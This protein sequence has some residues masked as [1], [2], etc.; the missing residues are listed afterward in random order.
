MSPKPSVSLSSAWNGRWLWV[1]GVLVALSALGGY[2]SQR[3]KT[4]V[5]RGPIEIAAEQLDFG[6]VPVQ[7]RFQWTV[8]LKNISDRTLRVTE[9]A[10][11]CDCT[12]IAPNAVS[13]APGETED[14]QLTLDL[15]PPISEGATRR[16]RPFSVNLTATIEGGRIPGRV[17]TISGQVRSPLKV[18]PS[19]VDFG[20]SL[21]EGAP[22]KPMSVVVESHEPCSELAASCNDRRVALTVAKV[23]GLPNR[24]RVS[25]FPSTKLPVGWHEFTIDLAPVLASGHNQVTVSIPVVARVVPEFGFAP[26]TGHLGGVERGQTL[27]ETATLFSRRKREFIVSKAV[28]HSPHVQVTRVPSHPA[29]FRIHCKNGQP[30]VHSAQVEFLIE[31]DSGIEERTRTFRYRVFQ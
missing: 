1:V 17:W 19:K 2:F 18:S 11:S 27:I 12:S 4:W 13:L 3:R 8:S 24:F 15:Q 31:T 25:V 10:A 26:A 16:I 20:E 5:D 23:D 28:S 7:K 6:L 14:I 30:G 29:A 22:F 21:V 9:L